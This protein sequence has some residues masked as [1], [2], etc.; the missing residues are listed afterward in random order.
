[1]T[2]TKRRTQGKYDL[3][4]YAFVVESNRI[5]GIYEQHR[6]DTH[7]HALKPLLALTSVTVRDLERFV[8]A[9]EPTAYLRTETHHNVWIGG[10]VAPPPGLSLPGLTRL[11]WEVNEDRHVSPWWVHR[12]YEHLHPFIDGN[13]RSGRALWLWMMI[14][15]NGYDLQYGFLQMFYY[16]TLSQT[17]EVSHAA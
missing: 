2:P 17:K 1:M 9:V 15:R 14:H 13:G 10:H 4:L 16:Q 8:K 6:H 12:E 5:E 11:L 7:Y 3:E